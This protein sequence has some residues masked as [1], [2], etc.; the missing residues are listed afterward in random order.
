MN[1][2]F[3]DANILM[4]ILFQRTK[5]TQ[6]AEFLS[7]NS[8][9]YISFLTIHILMYYT[10]LEKLEVQNTWQLIQNC[11]ILENNQT[12]FELAKNIYSGDDFED[13]LQIATC[14]SDEITTFITL[15]KNLAKNHKNLLNI[16]LL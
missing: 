2:V 14:L 8:N 12:T 1:K 4:E 16:V 7:Q 15:D 10:E 11:T 9:V 3:L 6:I 5:Y 13:C